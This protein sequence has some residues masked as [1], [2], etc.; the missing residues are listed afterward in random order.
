VVTQRVGFIGLGAMGARMARNLVG[1]GFPVRGH[2]REAAAVRALADAGG[3][4]AASAADAARDAELLV[5]IVFTAEQAETV[6]FGDGG[7]L[8]TL[9]AGATVLMSTTMAPARARAMEARL[10][11]SGHR[12][13]DAP[14]TGGVVGAADGTLT[15][16][17]SGRPEA[18]AA[19]RPAMEVMGAKIAAC[20]DHA[21]PGSTVKM[22][23]QLMCG[24]MVAA[25][26][27]GIALAAR[28]GADPRIAH[29]VIGSG[30]ARSLV[31]DSRVQ[32][33]LDG[34]FSP[35]GVVE[36]FT[37]DLDIVLQAGKDLSFPLPL[38][39]SAMQQFLAA[40]SLGF[41]RNDDAAVV[42]VYEQLGGVDVAAAA[43]NKEDR[44]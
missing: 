36:I 3:E 35:K 37:K 30:A 4:T 21:G 11:Q 12:F 8:E 33:I 39:A 13:L 1:A 38:T 32:S 18:L 5:I 14:C 27:E 28:A 25:A 22:V 15:F 10:A 40:Q 6:L 34:D 43:N 26:A 16:I 29:E 2:D 23:N 7:A 41:G 42:K 44:E 9:P 31:W 17:C 20:G 24:V 19:A